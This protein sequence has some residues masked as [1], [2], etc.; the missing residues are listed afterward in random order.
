MGDVEYRSGST[1][2]VGA[3]TY[4]ANEGPMRILYKCLVPIYEFPEMTLW[5]LVISK[6]EL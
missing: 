6:T 4:T 3:M 1:N 2:V 5:G